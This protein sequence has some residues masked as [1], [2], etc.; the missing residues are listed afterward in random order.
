MSQWN[1]QEQI[2][3]RIEPIRAVRAFMVERVLLDPYHLRGEEI[4]QYNHILR[5]ITVRN[6]AWWPKHT[7]E[8][9]CLTG[10]FMERR[11]LQELDPRYC[12]HK[13]RA[14]YNIA[15]DEGVTDQFSIDYGKLDLVPGPGC[16][17]GFWGLYD[18]EHVVNFLGG[19]LV[20]SRTFQY[21]QLVYG[22]VEM[23]GRVVPGSRGWRSQHAKVVALIDRPKDHAKLTAL[24]KLVPAADISRLI[25]IAQLYRVPILDGLP[26]DLTPPIVEEPPDPSIEF[27][28]QMVEIAKALAMS[29][30]QLADSMQKMFGLIDQNALTEMNRIIGRHTPARVNSY[31]RGIQPP[32]VRRQVPRRIF[33]KWQYKSMHRKR[34]GKR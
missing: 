16:A 15:D 33:P 23:W 30:D 6:A 9:K 20:G 19:Y 2:P 1:W 28:R 11:L 14:S 10:K 32:V 26:Q 3:D 13:A 27:Q 5:S 29:M 31:L 34:G 18:I 22:V 12:Y 21:R 24:D 17:C 4:E 25:S 8:A 7:L